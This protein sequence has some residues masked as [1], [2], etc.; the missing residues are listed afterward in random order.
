M[1]SQIYKCFAP[2]TIVANMNE[3]ERDPQ[4]F[5]SARPDD[6]SFSTVR[7]VGSLADV[8]FWGSRHQIENFFQKIKNFRQIATRYL[9]KDFMFLGAIHLTATL[10]NIR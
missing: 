8:L 10:I 1:Q 5:S 9:K 4:V 7:K 3:S 6:L 2:R